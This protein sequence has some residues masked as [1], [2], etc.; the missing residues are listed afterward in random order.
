MIGVT[1]WNVHPVQI[2]T[3]R[4][5]ACVLEDLG[6]RSLHSAGT[7]M[8]RVIFSAGARMNRVIFRLACCCGLRVSEIAALRLG[9]V[10]AQNGRPHLRVLAESSGPAKGAANRRYPAIVPRANTC[11]LRHNSSRSGLR[12]P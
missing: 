9:D 12:R 8:N 7:R 3:R 2:L 4:K 10:R 11:C 6:R 5:L 1:S